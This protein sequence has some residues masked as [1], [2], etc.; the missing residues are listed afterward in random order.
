MKTLFRFLITKILV[1]K[2]RHYL[3]KHR[4][5]VIAITGSIGKTSTK[6]AIA[7]LLKKQFKVYSSPKGFNTEVG[8]SLAILQEEQSGFSSPVAWFKILKRVLFK[9]PEPYQKIILEMGADKPGDIKKLIKIAPPKIGI[10]TNVNPVHLEKGQFENLEDIRKEKNSLIRHMPINGMAVL[11]FDD[12]M[13]KSMETSAH[14]VR[15]G[16]GEG[17]DVGVSDIT[18]SSKQIRFQVSY[19]GESLPFKVPLLGRFQVYVLLPAIAV[20]LKLGMNL[21]ECAEALADFKLP[22]SRMN[23]LPGINDS[24]IIDSSYNASPTSMTKAL[25]LLAELPAKRK[26]AVLGTMNELGDLNKEAHR[27]LGTQGAEAAKVL[28]AVGSEASTI[29]EGAIEAGMAEDNVYTFFDSEEAGH[30]L[31]DFL[32]P[33]DLIL[34]KG[35]QNRVRMERLVKL[36][37]KYPEKARDLLCRQDKAWEKI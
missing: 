36:I 2:A 8:I 35:S 29:K 23:P 7:H 14:R 24:T 16:L 5:Q 9:E 11:N 17:M 12:P 10:V 26:I 19:K 18:L 6:E 31:K 3:K 27:T 20:G 15:Y 1:H 25:E 22:S 33:D 28:I 34:V 21:Q 13:V 30:F 32:R 4:V 37:M